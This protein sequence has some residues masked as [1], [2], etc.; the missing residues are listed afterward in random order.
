MSEYRRPAT[1][2][3]VYRD[4]SGHPLVYGHRWGG[5]SPPEEA[6]SRVSDLDRFAP[7]HVVSLALIDWLLSTFDVTVDRNPGVAA[8]LLVPPTDVVHA[9]RIT[10]RNPAAAPLTFVLTPFPGVILH[11]GALH[12]FPFPACGCDACDDDVADLLD[13]L[14]GTVRGVVDGRYTERLPPE[15][16]DRVDFRL[17]EADRG[18]Q[19]GRTPLGELSANRVEAAR[20]ALP[21]AG[22]W[23][24]WR[25]LPGGRQGSNPGHPLSSV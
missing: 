11:A 21:A 15:S 18:T 19:A 4:E 20:G 2:V 9:V 13:G 7:L 14:E 24:P 6:Y 22:P 1:P 3:K 17:D 23:H 5:D 25:L 10:P 16:R 12:D 8:D